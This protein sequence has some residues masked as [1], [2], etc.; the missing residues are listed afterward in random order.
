[1]NYKLH[2]DLLIN[3]AKYRKLKEHEYREKHHIIPKSLG[4]LNDKEN[5][6]ELTAKEHFVAHHLLF[7]MAKT[8]IEKQKMGY[9]FGMMRR[10]N[11][12]SQRSKLKMT[13]RMY[14]NAKKAASIAASIRFTGKT[15]ENCES[16]RKQCNKIA[17]T[18]SNKET[19]KWYHKEHGV[20]VGTAFELS[21]KYN[22][23]NEDIISGNLLKVAYEKHNSCHGWILYK[24]IDKIEEI[25]NLNSVA[26]G[27]AGK[28]GGTFV[29]VTNGIENSRIDPNIVDEFI[30]MNKGWKKGITM[31]NNH[32][33]N[34]VR[35]YSPCKTSFV[36]AVPDSE[37]YNKYIALGY[38]RKEQVKKEPSKDTCIYCDRTLAKQQ[39]SRYHNEKCKM[40]PLPID[41]IRT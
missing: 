14:E 16:K 9:A 3:K 29:H 40:K 33:L 32:Q 35:L 12:H 39:I 41:D 34:T 36:K 18:L 26:A 19:F 37:K 8:Q 7:K 6:V 13:S 31:R 28:K 10:S 20:Y 5:L 4:G 38:D 15:K 23:E 21:K 17:L 24:N 27:I 25:M 11:R 30:S 22:N 1:M 2:Y